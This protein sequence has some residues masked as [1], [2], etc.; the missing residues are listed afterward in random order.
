M[1]TPV[2]RR[3]EEPFFSQSTSRVIVSSVSGTQPRSVAMPVEAEAVTLIWIRES[4]SVGLTE[5]LDS[6]LFELTGL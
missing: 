4:W 2:A 1:Y 6:D 3:R 5:F